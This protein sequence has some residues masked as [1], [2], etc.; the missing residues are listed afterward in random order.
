MPAIMTHDNFGQDMYKSMYRFIGESRDEFEA[1]LLGNQGPDPLFYLTTAPRLRKMSGFGTT[2]HT[3]KPTELIDALKQSLSILD[4]REYPVGRSYALGFLCHYILDSHMH[5]LVFFQQYQLENAGI[6]GLDKSNGR[7]LHA[8]IESEFDE[9]ALF[10]KRG[11]TV[12]RY[13]PATEILKAD[14][15]VLDTVS[16]MYSY[17]ALVVYGTFLPENMFA[18]SVGSFRRTEALFSSP[19]GTKRRILG[20]LEELVRPYSFVRAM[21]PRA[22]ELTE[23][24]FGN[25]EHAEWENP[26]TGERCTT[27]FW[28][29]YHSSLNKT[30]GVLGIFDSETF[31]REEAEG[32]TCNLNF[33][34]DPVVAVITVEDDESRSG[35]SDA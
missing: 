32:I 8:V 21:S 1:F 12:A 3:K 31:G 29:I 4:D 19:T 17:I 18:S 20:S 16:K 26:F 7:E 22:I 10:V 2:M 11:E 6:E 23:S 27:D 33:S 30:E 28:D 15:F 9:M 25:H 34:G 13:N 35:S 5:P 24:R 14:N